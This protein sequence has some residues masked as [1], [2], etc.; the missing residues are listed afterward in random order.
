MRRFWTSASCEPRGDG[1]TILVDGRAVRTPARADL[2]VPGEALAR[3]IAAEW[4][5]VAETIDAGSMPLTGLANAAIDRV[6]TART[7]FAEGL[8]SYAEGDLL[9]YRADGPPALAQ[10]QAD[11]WDPL[12]AWARRRFDV[13]F[14]VTTGVIHVAQPSAT[15]ARLSHA[16]AMLDPFRLAGLSPLVTIGGSLVAALAVLEREWTADAAWAAVSVD[17]AWQLEQWGEDAEG[18]AALDNR[19]RDFHAAASFLALL[20]A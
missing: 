6:A 10:R 7:A 14:A 5:A 9:C 16:V 3:A 4:N 13:D 12:L 18:R 19:R 11:A 15:V 8:A 20:D 17:E 2:V 1:W